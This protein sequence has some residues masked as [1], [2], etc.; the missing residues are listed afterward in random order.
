MTQR[1]PNRLYT[2]KQRTATVEFDMLCNDIHET[3]DVL[4]LLLEAYV[5][6]LAS[7]FRFPGVRSV[8]LNDVTPE[9]FEIFIG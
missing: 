5:P 7:L 6:S 4:H 9:S 2:S 8:R 3:F 1:P